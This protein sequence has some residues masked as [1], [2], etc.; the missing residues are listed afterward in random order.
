[1]NPDATCRP[2]CP[3]QFVMVIGVGNPHRSDDGAG[4]AVISRL[5]DIGM[6]DI[7]LVTLPGEATRLIDAWAM[8]DRV[9]LIDASSSSLPP[10]SVRR[11]DAVSQDLPATVDGSSSHGFGVA[12]AV[13]LARNLDLL[14][15]ELVV[16]TIEGET[17]ANGS[18]LS[19]RVAAAAQQ[20]AADLVRNLIPTETMRG[21]SSWFSNQ[22]SSAVAKPNFATV[23]TAAHHSGC[24][25][26]SLDN[27]ALDCAAKKKGAKRAKRVVRRQLR[28]FRRIQKQRMRD[29]LD[30]TGISTAT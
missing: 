4:H 19:P 8:A 17:F 30:N 7:E 18:G 29:Y 5:R 14:P 28:K 21:E 24:R 26:T 16:Y 15:A 22:S 20:L 9:I 11:F 2:A 23:A 27:V 1:M 6:P 3:Q 10:G 13:S 25:E 12:E